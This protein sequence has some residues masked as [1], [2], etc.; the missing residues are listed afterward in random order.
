[1]ARILVVDDDR[2]IRELLSFALAFEGH[3]VATLSDGS[4]VVAVLAAIQEPCIVL[5]DVMMPDVDGWEVCRRLE[6][7]PALL[8]HHRVILMTACPPQDGTYPPAVS[9]LMRK[10]FELDRLTQ[11][12]ATLV[13]EVEAPMTLPALDCE[14][15]ARAV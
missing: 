13:A 14:H 2:A 8:L 11:V 7:N 4:E 6:S 10:P 3:K 12:I 5:L 1:M 9:A 15:L